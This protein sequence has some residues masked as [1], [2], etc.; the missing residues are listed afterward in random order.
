[1]K[2]M[3][4]REEQLSDH[5]DNLNEKQNKIP[6]NEEGN[7]T[8]GDRYVQDIAVIGLSGRYPGA[9]HV[10]ELW[11]NVKAGR[12][13]I[14][15]VPKDRW[16][17]KTFYNEERGK[18]GS[19]YSKWGGFL[20]DI[21]TFD[22]LFFRISPAEAERMDPQERLFLQTAY[23]SIEDAGYTPATLCDSRKI[24]VFVGVMNSNYPTVPSD[25]SIANRVSF[26]FNFQGPSMAVDTACSSSL[27]AVHL[28]AESLRSGM[29][30]TAI[31]GGV[32][33]IVDPAHYER[34]SAF[35]CCLPVINANL[36]ET[37][38]TVLLTVKE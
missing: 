19:I 9:D 37:V 2:A 3:G 4:V 8:N 1:M 16:D 20:D 12:H 13:S 25:W 34:L 33:L 10:D 31:A 5:T 27:T 14:T 38:R 30:E 23:S 11:E 7:R 26:L 28:A 35:Q 6:Q 15:E 29:S 17:W 24:G 22:P 18:W 36:S 32:N 21:D